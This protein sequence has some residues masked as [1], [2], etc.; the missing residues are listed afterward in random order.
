M[1]N[2]RS[3]QITLFIITSFFNEIKRGVAIKT[4]RYQNYIFVV[5]FSTQLVAFLRVHGS[6]SVSMEVLKAWI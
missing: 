1:E 6:A 2:A 4:R 3:F 5:N